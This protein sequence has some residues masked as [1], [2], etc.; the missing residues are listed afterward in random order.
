MQ[1]F[2]LACTVLLLGC[3]GDSGDDPSGPERATFAGTYHASATAYTA[4]IF[5]ITQGGVTTDLLDL[6][7]VL[8][9][10][11]AEDGSTSGRM[12]VPG[13]DEDGSDFDRDLTGAWTLSGDTVR[14]E[15][16]A[17]T[18]L[19]DVP[20]TLSGNLLSGEYT[21]GDVVVRAVFVKD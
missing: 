2:A 14:F 21:S 16:D 19:R 17:D 12:F 18:F 10:T 15:H 13:A 5:T 4:S 7:G 20:F 8:D 3:G 9:L 11:L 6:G 1:A